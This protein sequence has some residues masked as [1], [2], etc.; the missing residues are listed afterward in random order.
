MAKTKEQ[1]QKI[2][3]GLK[4]K[5]KKQKAVVFMDFTGIKVDDLTDL[6]QEMK[7]KNCEIKIAKKTML[8]QAL[9]DSHPEIAKNIRGFQGEIGVAFGYND[10]VL[11][12]QILGKFSKK[13]K[14]L[15][16]LSGI[17]ARDFL[18]TEQAITVSMLSTKEDILARIVGSMS[19]PI[20]GFLNVLQGNVKSLLFALNAIKE[21]KS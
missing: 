21:T 20:S 9:K 7:N 11:P 13:H 8:E 17:I 6:R 14:N 2:I 5:I 15:K 3:Q 1:K 16:I 18:G 19:A 10:E 4:E 12:F